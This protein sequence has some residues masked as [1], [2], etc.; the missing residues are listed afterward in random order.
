M[1]LY[2]KYSVWERKASVK[3]AFNEYGSLIATLISCSIAVFPF[4]W[5]DFDST[6]YLHLLFLNSRRFRL[7]IHCRGNLSVAAA[8]QTLYLN[9]SKPTKAFGAPLIGV[10]V[11]CTEELLNWQ[12]LQYWGMI[13]RACKEDMSINLVPLDLQT[14]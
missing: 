3:I 11:S 12:K 8:I 7:F 9:Q 1:L 6:L 13:C 5:I 2:S 4:L 14:K 10:R